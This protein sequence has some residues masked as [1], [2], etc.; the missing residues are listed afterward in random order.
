MR[1]LMVMV[2]MTVVAA[3]LCCTRHT[4]GAMGFWLFVTIACMFAT[5]LVFIQQKIDANA[6]SETLSEYELKR[7][8][9]GKNPLRRN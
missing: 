3:M 4:G 7:L 9:E 1:W 6:R 2:M 5:T 8:R